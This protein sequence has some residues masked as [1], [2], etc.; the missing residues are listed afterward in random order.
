MLHSA[1]FKRVAACPSKGIYCL[2]GRG[3]TPL[4]HKAINSFR[5]ARVPPFSVASYASFPME[6]KSRNRPLATAFA[7]R[8]HALMRAQL[9]HHLSTKRAYLWARYT[10]MFPSDYMPARYYRRGGHFYGRRPTAYSC[11]KGFLYSNN[12]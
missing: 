6:V 2:M 8:K 1:A 7:L 9:E 11:L 10:V 5:W 3:E 4:A 12:Q